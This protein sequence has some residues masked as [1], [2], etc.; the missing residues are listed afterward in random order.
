MDHLFFVVVHGGAPGARVGG[1]RIRAR[2]YIQ[3]LMEVHPES[4]VEVEYGLGMDARLTK[5][6]RYRKCHGKGEESDLPPSPHTSYDEIEHQKVETAGKCELTHPLTCQWYSTN[7]PFISGYASL[8]PISRFCRAP[9]N[10]HRPCDNR[11]DKRDSHANPQPPKF[12]RRP[13]FRVC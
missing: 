10:L 1:F 4:A 12:W 13:T 8:R 3:K 9:R 5:A 6:S 7:L 2:L 11:H